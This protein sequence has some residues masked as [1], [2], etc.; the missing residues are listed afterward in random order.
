M[1]TPVE[2]LIMKHQYQLE[3]S[4]RQD[5]YDMRGTSPRT[6]ALEEEEECLKKLLDKAD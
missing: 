6:K 2:R 3:M 5:G 4:R 1:R